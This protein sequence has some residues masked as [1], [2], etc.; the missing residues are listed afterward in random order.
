VIHLKFSCG[1][2]L[3][4]LIW[5]LVR[6]LRRS[7][8]G[9][10]MDRQMLYFVWT[11]LMWVMALFMIMLSLCEELNTKQLLANEGVRWGPGL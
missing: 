2:Q 1:Y 11:S 4:R 3:K 5:V 7:L 9:M 8:K 10:F 6:I